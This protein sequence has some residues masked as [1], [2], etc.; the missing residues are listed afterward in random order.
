MESALAAEQL[1]LSEAAASGDSSPFDRGFSHGM[2]VFLDAFNYLKQ[3]TT[4]LRVL[5]I[6]FFPLEVFIAVC[7][8][9]FSKRF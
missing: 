6:L 3:K 1:C 2:G 4:F 5:N 7:C 8:F 9:R